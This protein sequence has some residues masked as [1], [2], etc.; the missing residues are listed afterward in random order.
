MLVMSL[1]TNL[2]VAL[3]FFSAN[4]NPLSMVSRPVSTGM[5]LQSQQPQSQSLSG[6]TTIYLPVI[7]TS[8]AAPAVQGYYVST[9]GSDSNPGTLNSPWRTIQHAVGAAPNNTTIYIRAGDY[10]GF[11]VERNNLTIS[12]YPGETPYV[13]NDGNSKYTV[14]VINSSGITLSGLVFRDNMQQ[15]GVGVH[16]EDSSGVLVKNSVFYDNQGFGVVTKNVTNVTVDGNDLYR[17]ANAIEI[18]YNG[19]GV[20]ISNNKIHH[21]FR[22]IDSGR[23]AMGINFYRTA[24]SITAIGNQLWENHSIGLDN[25][26]G[27]AFEVYAG[28]DVSIVGNIIW[29]NETVLETGTVDGAACS[30]ITFQRNIVFRGSRQQGLI[31]R[32]ASNSLFAHNIFDGLDEY[33]FYL[34]HFRGTYGGS[35]EGLRIF[36]NIAVNGRV[37]SIE[38]SIPASV[39]IDHNLLYNPGSSSSR[40][41]SLAYVEGQGNTMEI[42]KFQQWT[43]YDI[44]SRSLVPAF[45]NPA[46]IDYRPLGSSPSRNMGKYLGEPF[47]ESAPDA[48]AYEYAP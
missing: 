18:R 21:N 13:L 30:N 4:F 44:N 12:G 34:T 9:T 16:I 15:Y 48:G 41:D 2:L 32:C 36:N 1:F 19:N 43:G 38:G 28:G 10:S 17:N 35:I 47:L 6:T 27:S 37:Y 24:G 42:S 7:T 33:V 40:G 20:L 46:V 25:P 8:A 22:E 3:A 31:L 11:V 29:D 14:K 45:I 39:Q 5:L 26:E 23:G